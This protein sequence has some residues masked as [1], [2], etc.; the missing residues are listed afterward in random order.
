MVRFGRHDVTPAVPRFLEAARAVA[1]NAELHVLCT[2]M[3]RA[4]PERDVLEDGTH[5]TRVHLRRNR[6]DRIGPGA[7]ISWWV[8]ATLFLLRLRP[9]AVHAC[10]VWCHVP[11]LVARLI[12]DFRFIADVRDPV[13]ATDTTPGWLRRVLGAVEWLS[14]RTA[15]RVTV[16]DENRLPY[17]PA[18]VKARGNVAVIRNLPTRDCGFCDGAGRGGQTV[19]LALL[20]YLGRRRGLERLATLLDADPAVRLL[21]AGE[22]SPETA[23]LARLRDDRIAFH[24]R[25]NHRSSLAL[26]AESDVVVLLYDPELE[27]NRIAA[28]NKYYEALMVGRPILVAAD[29]PMARECIGNGCGYIVQYRDLGSL[30]AAIDSIRH[31]RAVWEEKCR[32]A[33]RVFEDSCDWLRERQKLETIYLSCDPLSAAQ[34]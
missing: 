7:V 4:F 25:L 20:G 3:S 21:I 5:I 1:P 24:G 19:R 16:P 30:K 34:S 12:V 23:I 31:E 15:F 26:M 2:R 9:D 13:R 10:D 6:A 8:S 11:C 18:G 29:T 17:V 33:R 28:P 27:A 14:L 22:P 32:R